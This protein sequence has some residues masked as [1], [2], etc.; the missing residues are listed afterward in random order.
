[1]SGSWRVGEEKERPGVYRRHVNAGGSE[2]AGTAENVGLAVVSGT[3]GPLNK[4]VVTDASDDIASIIGSGKGANV[5]TQM[6]IGGANT[7]MVVRVGSGGTP[8][9]VTL[10]DNKE[11]DVVTLTTLYPTSRALTVTIKESLEDETQKLAIIQEGTK[12]LEAVAFTAGAT[13]VAGIVAAF[14]DSVYVKAVKK[15]DGSGTLK[16]ISQSKFSGGTDPTVNTEAY[17]AGFE[18]SE[19]ETWDGVA[20]D[21][22]D[23]AVHTLLYTFINRRFEEGMYPYACVGEP[24][25]V[26]IDTRIQ[27]AAAFNDYKMHYVLNSWVGTDGV[28]YEGYLAAARILG[29]IIAV[30]SNASLTHSVITGAASLN[31]ALKNATIKKALK[32]GC[33]VLSLSKSRQVWIEKAI[34]T[35][36]VLSADQDAGWKKIRRMKTRFE[37][38]DRIDATLEAMDGTSDNN[39]N[40]RATVMSAI[41]D[42]LDAMAG[43][44]KVE[45]GGTVT[46][47]T[48]NPPKGDSAWF[49]I[50]VDDIDSMELIYLT[51]RYRFAPED[52]EE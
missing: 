6:R 19:E 14:A 21:S 22:D 3:W 24:K 47:D 2:I 37:L 18:A 5:I 29:M 1:M 4:P 41:V 49:N 25:S 38:E 51:Y 44:N 30:A 40:G 42:I 39:D 50:S 13:E 20:V 32:S 9:S 52:A 17:S 48:S 10:K 31:E 7:I 43:E 23:P 27:H 34:N 33:L 46:L 16:N 11:A 45:A 12:E 8:A 36:T 26:A 35:L 28:V 15:A